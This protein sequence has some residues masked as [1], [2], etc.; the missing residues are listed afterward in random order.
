MVVTLSD[1]P[2]LETARLVIR[3]PQAG[4]EAALIP[5]AMSERAKFVGGSTD[6]DLGKAW[7]IFAI[8]AGHWVARG[9][10]TFVFCDHNSGRP[11]GSAGPWFPGNW[12]EQ[13]LGWTIWDAAD[14]GR[15]LAFEAMVA[16]RDHA[17]GALGWTTAVSYIDPCNVRSR[18]LAERLGCTLDNTA[19][20]PHTDIPTVVYRHPALGGAT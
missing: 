14:E 3:S 8:M 18:A 2:V 13:E 15:G 7:R 5:F 19:P 17:F 1:A 10:G 4:D 20:V 12:P 11:I 6:C 9:Y 16:I